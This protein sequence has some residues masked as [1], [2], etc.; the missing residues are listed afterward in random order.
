MAASS[1]VQGAPSLIDSARLEWKLG[2]YGVGQG[3]D[4]KNPGHWQRAQEYR[5]VQASRLIPIEKKDIRPR[6][7]AGEYHL[8]RKVDG[9]LAILVFDGGEA[10]LVNPGGTVR[11]GLPLLAD[12][13][14]KLTKAGV[15]S[16]LIAGEL[17]YR[18]PDGSRPR[19][20][21]VSRAARS[22]ASQDDLDRLC[23]A[24]FDVIEIDGQPLVSKHSDVF[25]KITKLFSGKDR[26]H[27]VDATTVKTP[28]EIEKYF[29]DWVE[30]QGGEGLVLRS[31]SV[32]SYKLK[33][34]HN[35]DVAVIGYTEGTEDRKGMLHD[36]L[37]AVIR[38]DGSFQIIGRVGTG[39]SDEER[40]S[41]LSDLRALHSR[42]DYAEIG[43]G[44]VAYQMVRPDW[45]IEV[46]CLDLI[47][48]TSRSGIIE[49]MVLSYD[50]KLGKWEP[51]RRM[52]LA[53]LISPVYVRRREDKRPNAVDVRAQQIADL[54]EIALLDKDARTYSL[55]ASEVI[56]REVY[57][58]TLKG[59]TAVR[60]LLLWKTN[61]EV[62]GGFPAYVLHYTDYSPTRKE[63]LSRD[64][65][66]SNSRDQIEALWKEFHTENIVKGWNRA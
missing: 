44:H 9:E 15:K 48:Q 36:L 57:V 47:V 7:P 2:K 16:A 6:L 32:G 5:R 59:Q 61:K 55:P 65:R 43:D 31:D 38:K 56:R 19:V 8:S 54:A 11:V 4:L 23:L 13:G 3:K 66:I 60:K 52:P 53:S 17:Y 26:V 1:K 37:C 49:R 34:R 40:R 58:K 62:D 45:V 29:A 41:L 33:P 63:P 10:L 39:F 35:I 30:G 46:S 21:D 42:S 25:A 14:K 20:H 51:V 64:I 12:A 24:V 28:E 22:P 18:H 27:P 50:E